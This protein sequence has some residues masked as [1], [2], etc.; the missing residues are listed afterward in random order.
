MAEGALS[1]ALGV[2]GA[3]TGVVAIWVT[4]KLSRDSH[5]VNTETLRLLGDIKSAT[6]AAEAATTGVSRRLIEGMLQLLSRAVATDLTRG[7]ETAAQQV[8]KALASYFADA[9][10][11]LREK[12]KGSILGALRD[13]NR[14]V[15]YSLST[16]AEVPVK[17]PKPRDSQEVHAVAPAAELPPAV[18][19]VLG[20]MVDN[21]GKYGFFGAHLLRNQVFGADPAE[22]E[23]FQYCIEL[24]MI[25]LYKVPNPRDPDYPVTACRLNMAHPDVRQFLAAKRGVPGRR[26][27]T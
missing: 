7:E 5:D 2:A 11:E 12:A 6:N 24:G 1:L 23:A 13:A 22:A 18:T 25:E 14:S 20:W 8:D 27:H 3:V 4:L 19:R 10:V 15:M 17:G 21:D 9:S 16:L 26:H